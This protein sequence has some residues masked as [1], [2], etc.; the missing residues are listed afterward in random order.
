MCCM[1]SLDL[2]LFFYYYFLVSFVVVLVAGA[3]QLQYAANQFLICDDF[4]E[5]LMKEA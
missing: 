1:F 5:K 3:W 4:V 2:L